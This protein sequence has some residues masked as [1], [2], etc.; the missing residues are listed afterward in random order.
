MKCKKCNYEISGMAKF[1]PQC[2]EKVDTERYCPNCGG[3]LREG[4]KFCG[5]CGYNIAKGEVVDGSENVEDPYSTAIAQNIAKVKDDASAPAPLYVTEVAVSDEE[6]K[7]TSRATAF[8]T[9]ILLTFIIFFFPICTVSCAGQKITSPNAYEIAYNFGLNQTQMET[10]DLT[11]ADV[12]SPL[13]GIV[14]IVMAVGLLGRGTLVH[15]VQAAIAFICMLLLKHNDK[16]MSL[17]EVGVDIEFTM[18]YNLALVTLFLAVTAFLWGPRILS[19]YK[20]LVRLDKFL[21]LAILVTIIVAVVLNPDI[22]TGIGAAIYNHNES[23]ITLDIPEVPD[24]DEG[25]A[26]ESTTENIV[27]NNQIISQESAENN[28]VLKPGDFAY[29]VNCKESI[30]LREEPF[31]SAGEICQMPLFSAVTYLGEAENGFYEVEYYGLI[32]YALAS[33]LDYYEPQ[34]YT[35]VTC[36]VV[37]CKESIMLRTSPST[38]ATEICQIPLGTVVDY[39]EPA[40]NNFYLVSYSGHI[41]YALADYLEIQ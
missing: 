35:G 1:C 31:T 14:L 19:K 5:L 37:N 24:Y 13:M 4:A 32:G 33:Y 7:K 3:Q 40:A 22:F 6:E 39:I 26:V 10:L 2:G 17:S 41:G 34:I 15:T 29:V 38:K 28:L 20:N 30:T 27:Y 21:S 9:M 12:A 18:W 8:K 25:K 16:T 11:I 23:E 36:R